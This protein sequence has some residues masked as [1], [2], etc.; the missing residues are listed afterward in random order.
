[1][2]KGRRTQ[3]DGGGSEP[4]ETTETESWLGFESSADVGGIEARHQRRARRSAKSAGKYE[5]SS[6]TAE[7]THTQALTHTHI[8]WG[9]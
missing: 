5:K 3:D 2:A 4:R 6:L 8:D 7:Q 9:N 1:V